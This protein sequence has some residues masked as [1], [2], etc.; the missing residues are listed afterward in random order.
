MHEPR[1]TKRNANRKRHDTQHT[2]YVTLD[3]ASEKIRVVDDVVLAAD[4][5]FANELLVFFRRPRGLVER[6]VRLDLQ[7]MGTAARALNDRQPSRET[8]DQR[9]PAT[10]HG[11]VAGVAP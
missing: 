8:L 6:P 1:I 4:R 11:A 7:T 9:L 3:Q 10:V 5:R 2:R